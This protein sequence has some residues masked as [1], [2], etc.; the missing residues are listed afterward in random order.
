LAA[1]D[2]CKTSYPSCMWSLIEGALQWQAKDRVSAKV[3][4]G[5]RCTCQSA[6]Q[7]QVGSELRAF[8]GPSAL[9]PVAPA[10]TQLRH[11]KCA[12]S[13]H[14]YQPGHK[15]NGCSSYEVVAGSDVCVD[16]KCRIFACMRPRLGGPLCSMHRRTYEKSPWELRAV[17]ELGSSADALMPMDITSFL[18]WFPKIRSSVALCIVVAVLKEPS[19]VDEFLAPAAL[20]N[21]GD[22]S[23]FVLRQQ[24]RA[25]FQMLGN[26]GNIEEL[27]QMAGQG[28]YRFTGPAAVLRGLDIA[29]P[30]KH[31][32]ADGVR[33]IGK[34]KRAYLLVERSSV[35]ERFLALAQEH[36]KAWDE[37]LEATDAETAMKAVRGV[38][39]AVLMKQ[40]KKT[41]I[42]CA[43]QYAYV[44]DFI[45]RKLFLGVWL[46]GAMRDMKW[47]G[48]P[49]SV[50][51]GV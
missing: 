45:A 5:V 14:C 26:H 11:A 21:E 13:R 2:D 27:E 16:C 51:R 4:A 17:F 29:Q 47:D 23:A 36:R 32:Y 30:T 33:T 35:L 20:S 31:V 22:P 44:F 43:H 3:A 46:H 7:S 42:F 37:V 34:K 6:V 10:S 1:L 25:V 8:T 19:A 15:T 18:D 50:V 48:V 9:M 41:S 28:A 24:L 49:M 40:D 38:L 39:T 12:C